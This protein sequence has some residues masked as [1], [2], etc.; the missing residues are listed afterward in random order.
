[1]KHKLFRFYSKL[2]TSSK[3]NKLRKYAIV[4]KLLYSASTHCELSWGKQ[5]LLTLQYTPSLFRL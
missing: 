5:F 2:I 1:M 3:F 4:R